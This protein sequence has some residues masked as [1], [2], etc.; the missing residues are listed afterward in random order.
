MDKF[1]YVYL[2]MACF[3]YVENLKD[4]IL[5]TTTKKLL[6]LLIE[7]RRLQD[8][9]SVYKSQLFFSIATMKN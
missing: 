4:A 8:T 5:T 3:V 1:Y 2:Q 7:F 6:K 9:K